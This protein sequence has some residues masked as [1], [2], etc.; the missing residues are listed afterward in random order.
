MTDYSG[1]SSPAFGYG[2]HQYG[3]AS[4]TSP[5]ATYENHAAAQ[6]QKKPPTPKMFAPPAKLDLNQATELVN[7]CEDLEM[8][9]EYSGVVPTEMES[10]LPVSL[11]LTQ[12][13]SQRLRDCVLFKQ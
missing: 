6:Q 7:E 10:L 2:Q 3:A 9:K 11:W 4:T 8:M 1:V 5:R 12:S 13:N